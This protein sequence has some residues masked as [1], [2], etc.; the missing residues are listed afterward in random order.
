MDKRIHHIGWLITQKIQ[1]S[2]IMD[3]E[4]IS[5]DWILFH[6][7]KL[8]HNTPLEKYNVKG[9]DVWVKRD[10]LHNDLGLPRLR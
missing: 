9:I 8:N 4:D 5:K 2:L 7:G 1:I 10:D 6:N 3:I